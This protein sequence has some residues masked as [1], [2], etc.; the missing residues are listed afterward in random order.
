MCGRARMCDVCVSALT[1]RDGAMALPRAILHRQSTEALRGDASAPATPSVRSLLPVDC[2]H[3]VPCVR[4][5]RNHNGHLDTRTAV[6]LE[7]HPIPNPALS[8][9][10]IN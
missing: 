6:S 10:F 4:A 1:L 2:T 8:V 3:S 5:Q 7:V 9:I